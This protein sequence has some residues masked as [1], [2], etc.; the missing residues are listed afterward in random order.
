MRT[1]E[2]I[3]TTRELDDIFSMQEDVTRN[4]PVPIGARSLRARRLLSSQL[5]YDGVLVNAWETHE[6]P[7]GVEQR[8]SFAMRRRVGNQTGPLSTRR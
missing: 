8:L 6:A 3:A 4:N 7:R 1:S 2:Q 5:A